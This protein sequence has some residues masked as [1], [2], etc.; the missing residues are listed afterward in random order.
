MTDEFTRQGI[1]DEEHLKLLSLGYIIS[2]ATTAFFSLFGLMYVFMGIFIGTIGSHQSETVA[3]A[4][5][6]GQAP[7][8]FL[9]WFFTMIGIVFFVI[10]MV[11]AAAKLQTAFWI[12]R[13]KAR[14]LCMVVAGISCLGIP[15]GTA[16]GTLTFMVLGRDSVSRL[17][18]ATARA[19]EP[20]SPE[21]RV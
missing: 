18:D 3:V 21:M 20:V 15:Y 11:L 12:K 6:S 8:A 13:R 5:R 1:L 7:P 10:A 17:F 4:S 14:T 9:G 2:A 16:L 19:V